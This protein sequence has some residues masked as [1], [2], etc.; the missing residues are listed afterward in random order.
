M[1]IIDYPK[2]SRELDSLYKKLLSG[3]VIAEQHTMGK[4]DQDE[5]YMRL[6]AAMIIEAVK[7]LNSLDPDVRINAAEYFLNETGAS[8]FRLWLDARDMEIDAETIISIIEQRLLQDRKII[9]VYHKCKEE[10]AT[11]REENERMA[12]VRIPKDIKKLARAVS[13]RR[14]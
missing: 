1:Q 10:R 11:R 3:G 4:D 13:K 9:D 14:G 6:F 5:P 8:T 12:T 7:D 2:F